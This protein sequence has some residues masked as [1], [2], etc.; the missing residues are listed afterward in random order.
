M[1][2]HPLRK[3]IYNKSSHHTPLSPALILIEFHCM[4]TTKLNRRPSIL[5]LKDAYIYGLHMCPCF[6]VWAPP[7]SSWVPDKVGKVEW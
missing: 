1:K 4:R 6:N 3:I 7:D 2:D 5:S